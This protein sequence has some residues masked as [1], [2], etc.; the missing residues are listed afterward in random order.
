MLKIQILTALMLSFSF[1]NLVINEIHYNPDITLEGPD[2][3]HEFIE[4]YNNSE[5]EINLCGYSIYMVTHWGWWA[6]HDLI[7]EFDE[8]HKIEPYAHEIISSNHSI[9]DFSLENWHQDFSLPNS[10]NTALIIYNPHHDPIDYVEYDDGHPWPNEADGDGYSLSLIDANTDNS[11]YCNWTIS[12]QVGGTPGY[13]N[14]GEDLY[15]CTDA[16]ACNYN[17]LANTDSGNCEYYEDCLGE[18]GGTADFDECGVCN[19]E[20]QMMC[21]DGS[22]VCSISDCPTE[23]QYFSNLPPQTGVTNLIV[24]SNIL[25]LNP[26]DEVGLFD[27]NGQLN[28][29]DCSNETGELLVGS[30]VFNGD[31]LEIVATGS[32]D[33]CDLPDGA[34]Y[35]GFISGNQIVIRLWSNEMNY[36]YTPS[37]LQF[38]IGDGT[39]GNL[40]TYIDLLDANIYGCTDFEASNYDMYATVDNGSCYYTVTQNIEIIPGFL[41]N[42]S[43]NVQLEDMNP[44]NLFSDMDILIASNDQGQYYMPML[45]INSIEEMNNRDGYLVYFSGEDSQILS[46]TGTPVSTSTEIS[47]DPYSINYIGYTPQYEMS[48]EE[49]FNGIPVFIVGDQYGNYYVP[50]LGINTIDESGGMQPGSG[51]MV[52][53]GADDVI[54]FTYPDQLGREIISNYDKIDAQQSLHF[55]V[56]KTGNPHP[57]L[58]TEI[59]GNYDIG[60]EIVAYS[61][62]VV[63][64]AV[65]IAELSTNIALTAWGNL[66]EYGIESTGF[67]KGDKIELKLWRQTDNKE[68]ELN[69]FLDNEHYGA[70]PF[71]IGK[72]EIIESINMPTT[73]SLEQNYPNPFNPNTMI[74][75][76]LN[77]QNENTRLNIYDINGNHVISLLDGFMSEGYHSVEWNAVDKY[78]SNV[79]AGIY[80]YSLQ[81][82]NIVFTRKMILLK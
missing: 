70:S 9:Y 7:I 32:L 1:S 61:E 3:N 20:G 41:N 49:V 82:G 23:P 33:Y 8:S 25:G 43:L 51:Y 57:I 62:N 66:N 28:S 53:H 14:F 68:L 6:D 38:S 60:D 50:Q 34:Q 44:I 4:I 36:E 18:C 78:G 13:V 37:D 47:M 72:V 56:V 19:G 76:N 58:I 5:H 54:S 69:T 11:S 45:G 52:Y 80:F 27:L 10:E 26:G 77:E 29:N 79:P 74:S 67:E 15:G 16:D 2:V 73:F 21:W 65:R 71:S 12:N 40:V 46:L 17:P 64:G 42:I 75:F 22:E 35:P 30:G 24:I 39:W 31:Q 81:A 48:V 63:V 55:D 59:F